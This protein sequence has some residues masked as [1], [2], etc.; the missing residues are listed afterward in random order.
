MTTIVAFQG[1]GWSVIGSESRTTVENRI[2]DDST[3]KVRKVGEI[4]IAACGDVRGEDIVFHS[5]R[6]PAI[7]T[8]DLNRYVRSSLIPSL[9]KAFISSGYEIQPSNDSAS[10]S[11]GFIVSVRGELFQIWMDY[12]I[13]RSDVYSDG[14]GGEFAIGAAEALGIR[15]AETAEKAE[16]ILR[17]AIEVAKLYD[18]ASGGQV[19]TIIH[20]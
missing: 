8:K 16:E 9:R 4:V 11:S 7:R 1:P 14:S 2:I 13:T 17:Q 18:M 10:H 3:I 15:S 19:W 12:A 5:W 6:P 20:K